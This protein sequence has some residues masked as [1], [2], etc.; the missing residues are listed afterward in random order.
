M[1][2]NA[3]DTTCVSSQCDHKMCVQIDNKWILLFPKYYFLSVVYFFFSFL[4][5]NAAWKMFQINV[6]T[7]YFVEAKT[8]L[9]LSTTGLFGNVVNLFILRHDA[10]EKGF[11]ASINC[12]FMM[13]LL[14]HC[15]YAFQSIIFSSSLIHFNAELMSWQKK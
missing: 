10:D 13:F 5:L 7:P 11:S 8:N 9:L 14:A 12:M 15:C 3:W 1:S 2:L 4:S 6:H